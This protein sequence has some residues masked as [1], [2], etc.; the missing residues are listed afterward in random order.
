[1]KWGGPRMVPFQSDMTSSSAAI[2]VALVYQGVLGQFDEVLA[3]KT[4][5]TSV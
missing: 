5:W 4:T 1:M 3:L 2:S